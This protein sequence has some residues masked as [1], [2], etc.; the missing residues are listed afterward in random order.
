MPL[1]I[2]AVLCTSAKLVDGSTWGCGSIARPT[3][4]KAKRKDA[5]LGYLAD[6]TSGTM[7]SV[8]R[9]WTRWYVNHYRYSD[10]RST[11][12]RQAWKIPKTRDECIGRASV[13]STEREEAHLELALK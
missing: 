5:L 9:N 12:V 10:R 2:R 8:L 6:G 13:I 11:E 4:K 7:A 1:L 3:K